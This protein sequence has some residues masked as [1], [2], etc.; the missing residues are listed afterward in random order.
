LSSPNWKW[1][2]EFTHPT[3]AHMHGV[4]DYL[5]SG[6]TQFQEVEIV[7]TDFFGRCL[8]LDGK[9]QS[10]QFDEHI[11]HEALIHPAMILHPLP[12]KILVVG[13]GEGAVLREILKH[14]SVE[15]LVMV[16]IDREVVEICKRYLPS[17]SQ[18]AYKDNRV[19]TYFMD[20]R[21]Y[22]E[23]NNDKWDLIYMDLTEPLDD[24]ASYLLFTKE[25]Y[26]L[27]LKR[28]EEGGGIALQAGNF[29]PGLF[30]CHAAIY[31]TLKLVFKHVDSYGTF[32]PSFDTKWGFIYASMGNTAFTLDPTKIDEKLSERNIQGLQF[33]DGLTHVHMF[34]LT[35]DLRQL[36]AR[37][38]RIIEDNKP[39]F[40]Y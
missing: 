19:E 35:K 29:N 5:Y 38:L 28:L 10:A 8:I 1:F 9:I 25:F 18:D 14:P 22:L 40:T 27:V 6:S 4:K 33:Y 17:W 21:K 16:D 30:Q 24:S 3:Q 7:E 37:E 15:K 23:E 36:R 11:Y 12:K 39:L 26:S 32:I 20:A 2:I 31:N 34:T 13:G